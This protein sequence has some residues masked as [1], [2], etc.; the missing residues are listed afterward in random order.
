MEGVTLKSPNSTENKMIES[1]KSTDLPSE[2][3]KLEFDPN[4]VTL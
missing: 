2:E 3:L 4:S 1:P